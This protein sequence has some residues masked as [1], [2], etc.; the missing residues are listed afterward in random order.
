MKLSVVTKRR[1][2]MRFLRQKFP[3]RKPITVRRVAK[4]G[5][6]RDQADCEFT[7][8]NFVIRLRKNQSHVLLV[9]SLIHEW[10]HALT[11]FGAD[12]D[13]HGPEWGLA[14]AR[15]YRAFLQWNYGGKGGMEE[16]DGEEE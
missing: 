3:V 1:M 6:P 10:A 5:H 12:E 9:D 8:K 15:I 11:W 4:L 2:L 14:Y 7:G 16:Y 13:F